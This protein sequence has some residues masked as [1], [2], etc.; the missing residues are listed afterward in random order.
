MTQQKPKHNHTSS[1]GTR[2][3]HL[4]PY[5][6]IKVK[7]MKIWI[8]VHLFMWRLFYFILT[9][10]HLYAFTSHRFCG[11]LHLIKFW[12]TYLILKTSTMTMIII[13]NK[14]GEFMSSVSSNL[15]T[16]KDFIIILKKFNY[17][18]KHYVYDNKDNCL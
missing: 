12:P 5:L 16:H 7:E 10:H 13:F 14:K 8:F 11:G 17:Y 2:Y 9:C 18:Y 15:V 1:K 4:N 3:N 6:I